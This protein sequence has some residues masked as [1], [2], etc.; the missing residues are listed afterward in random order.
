MNLQKATEIVLKTLEGKQDP[1]TVQYEKSW[2][3][4]GALKGYDV[5]CDWD[6]YQVMID[7]TDHYVRVVNT[8]DKVPDYIK[9]KHQV[10]K[11]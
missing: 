4:T 10:I 11:D 2:D 6:G 3:E 5:Y 8:L 7:I 1:D 9:G